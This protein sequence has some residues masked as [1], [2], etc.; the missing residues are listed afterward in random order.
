MAH[1]DD[2][3]LNAL[4]DGEVPAEEAVAVRAHLTSCTECAARFEEA[5]RF[6]AEAADLLS[7][8]APPVEERP[9]AAAPPAA[10][11]AAPATAPGTPAP[12]GA[13]PRRVSKTAREVAI[14][15]DGAT[16]KSPAI[17][18][19]FPREGEVVAPPILGPSGR[20]L[21][22]G[23]APPRRLRRATDWPTLAWAA[24]VVLALGVGYLANEVRHDRQA[25][26][27]SETALPSVPAGAAQPARGPARATPHSSRAGAGQQK[28]KGGAANAHT[29][30]AHKP[31]AAQGR[32]L[33][34]PPATEI[35]PLADAIRPVAPAAGGGAAVA[36]APSQMAG[37]SAVP[38]ANAPA[39]ERADQALRRAAP[40]PAPA[41][42][43]AAGL[44]APAAASRAAAAR[45]RAAPPASRPAFRSSDVDEAAARLSRN[46]RFVEGLA[47]EGV[48]IGPGSL[49]PGADPARDVVRVVYTDP[50]GRRLQLDQQR[51]P[52]PQDT[53]RAARE[54]AEPAALGLAWGD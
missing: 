36:A 9:A 17:P 2:G 19:N 39:Q 44:Q 10:R 12:A 25:T 50:Q 18:P 40:S 49:V 48:K 21:F 6:L 27:P 8:L 33:V 28:A 4:L 53:G 14:D 26:P 41:G 29:A 1:V 22:E 20:P 13:P 42:N 51:I 3:T 45:G 23:S 24:S 47:L 5:K 54:R 31:A 16:H 46:L 52:S 7:A 11:A 38:P 43:L 15:I 30:L 37:V 35:A 34:R 32:K